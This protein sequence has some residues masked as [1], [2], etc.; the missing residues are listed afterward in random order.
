MNLNYKKVNHQQLKLFDLFLMLKQVEGFLAE[1]NMTFCYEYLE[2]CISTIYSNLSN[3]ENQRWMRLLFCFGWYFECS[4]CLS[5]YFG[6]LTFFSGI[7][8][9]FFILHVSENALV[10]AEK[11][12]QLWC[13]L[14]LDLLTCQKYANSELYLLKDLEV[15]WK[16]LSV[17]RWESITIEVEL[18]MLRRVLGTNPVIFFMCSLLQSW[19]QSTPHR[20]ERFRYWR[21]WHKNYPFCGSLG[22]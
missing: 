10:N 9:F 18:F 11:L 19:I 14:Q 7:F 8:T 3:M 20:R 16:V 13:M 4:L 12:L 17:K 5:E 1:K 15:P 2:Q 6:F 21:K 22:L